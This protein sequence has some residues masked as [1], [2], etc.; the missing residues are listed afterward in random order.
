MSPNASPV[1]HSE[2]IRT[3][4]VF[5]GLQMSPVYN[6]LCSLPS[7]PTNTLILKFPCSVGRNESESIWIGVISSICIVI[8][9]PRNSITLWKTVFDEPIWKTLSYIA[10]VS[11]YLRWTRSFL[12]P[13]ALAATAFTL[14]MNIQSIQMVT[15]YYTG[16]QLPEG[17]ITTLRWN[18][19]YH[20]HLN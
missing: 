8:Q 6:V 4:G 7:G 19:Q 5:A 2:W 12:K 16:W 11:Y 1:R 10:Q 17:T 3:I 18:I 20:S 13:P 14:S 15:S 9:L